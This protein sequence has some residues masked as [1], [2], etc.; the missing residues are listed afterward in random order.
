MLVSLQKDALTGARVRNGAYMPWKTQSR[1]I[2]ESILVF[3]HASV[4]TIMFEILTNS[5][6]YIKQR[7]IFCVDR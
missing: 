6:F 5:V 2:P 3:V 7:I 4:A 1:Q